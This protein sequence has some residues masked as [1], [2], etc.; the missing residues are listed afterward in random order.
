MPI[1]ER[2][3]TREQLKRIEQEKLNQANLL[4]TRQQ[5]KKAEDDLRAKQTDQDLLNALFLQ[6]FAD[7]EKKFDELNTYGDSGDV[8]AQ[9]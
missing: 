2:P 1:Y 3:P 5:D 9:T 8:L 6:K 7:L 4:A